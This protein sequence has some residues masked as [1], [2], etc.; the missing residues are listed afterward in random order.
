MFALSVPWWE[1]P[2]RVVIIYA[3]LLVLMRLSGKRTVGQFT[4]FDLLV[5]LLLSETVTSGLVGHDHSITGALL[6]AATLVVLNLVVAM[7][8]ARSSTAQAL[9]EGDAVLIGRDG[10]L[11]ANVLQRNHVPRVD[12][13]RA[14]READ[15]DL[16]DM[17]FAFLEAD[18]GIS[19]LKD[20]SGAVD[21][22]G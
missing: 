1:L 15:C 13:E 16:R 5:V 9:V 17:K 20:S 10:H 3:A 19:I 7:V 18:G 6:A 11:F 14:L 8:I 22:E 12:V 4:P 2:V 21:A